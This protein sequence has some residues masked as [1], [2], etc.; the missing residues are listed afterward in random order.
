MT[1]TKTS[2]AMRNSSMTTSKI[3][4]RRLPA[5]TRLLSLAGAAAL[6]LCLFTMDSTSHGDTPAPFT[7]PGIVVTRAQLDFVKQKIAAGV[8]PWAKAFARMKTTPSDAGGSPPGMLGYQANAPIADS[9][10]TDFTPPVPKGF[11]YCGSVSDPDVFCTFEKE[12]GVAAY[13][14]ALLWY[15]SPDGADKETYRTTAIDILNKWSVLQDH[16]GYNSGLESGWM[17]TEFARAAEIMQMPEAKWA[18]ADIDAFKAMMRRA[19]LGRLNQVKPGIARKGDSAYGQ[20]GN[21]MLSIADS[22]IQIGVLLDDHTVFKQGIDLWRDRTPAYCYYSA[23]DGSN[24]V[25]PCSGYSPLGSGFAT[26]ASRTA[27]PYGYFGQAG[28][29]TPSAAPPADAGTG[30]AAPPIPMVTRKMAD[31]T[32]H[33][34]CRDLDHVQYGLAAMMSGAE[35]ARIQG[36][37]LYYEQAQRIVACMEFAANYANKAIADNMGEP[38][39]GTGSQPPYK[40]PLTKDIIVKASDPTLC[41]D[42][43]GT[44]RILLLGTGSLTTFVIE[45][46]WE[47]GYNEFANRLGMSMPNTKKLITRYRTSPPPGWIGATHHISWEQV[48]HADVGSVGLPVTGCGLPL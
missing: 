23:A 36:V 38:N 40:I 43:N 25:L 41:P 35:T 1:S 31:G 48:T 2:K 22:I 7:H 28:G 30:D 34:T 14:Q 3:F 44:A 10:G 26:K 8:D 13:T 16:L 29:V 15:L 27:D 33:E 21:W 19:Y 9:P 45:P 42:V 5:R 11:V 39:D 24:P 6:G 47:I 32:S 46:T 17:A 37:D 20:N 4:A 12:D 18:Q